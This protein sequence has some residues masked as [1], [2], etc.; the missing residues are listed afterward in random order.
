MSILEIEPEVNNIEIEHDRYGSS[1]HDMTL[2][3]AARCTDGVVIAADTKFTGIGTHGIHYSYNNKITGELEG[4]LTA[5]AGDIGTFQLFATALREYVISFKRDQKP[6]PSL[7]QL[8]LRISEIQGSFYSK[9]EKYK[10]KIFMGVSSK[11]ITNK[12]SSLYYFDFD[13]RCFPLTQPKAIG[14]GSQYALYFLKRYWQQ[15]QTTMEQ[16]AQLSDF[17]IRY[18]SHQSYRLDEAVGL[19]DLDNEF[20]Y[21]KIVYIPDNPDFCKIYNSGEP[22]TD[23]LANINRLNEARHNSD[24]MIEKLHRTPSPWDPTYEVTIR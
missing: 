10:C 2:I 5:F 8:I 21:P 22:K 3:L 19:D 1:V 14:S 20:Q 11:F 13:G 7:D 6:G 9:Y 15:N 16:F 24:N 17:I 23:C 4:M 12:M 18:V